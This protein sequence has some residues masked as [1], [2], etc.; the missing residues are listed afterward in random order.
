[1]SLSS[2]LI[3]ETVFVHSDMSNLQWPGGMYQGK[4]SSNAKEIIFWWFRVLYIYYIILV[5]HSIEET[6]HK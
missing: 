4:I 1:M 5:L 2:S 3:F 6:Y